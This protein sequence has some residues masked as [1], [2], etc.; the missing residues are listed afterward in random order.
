MKLK[1]AIEG[2][3]IIARYTK[4]EYC[5]GAEHDIFLCGNADLPLTDE[6]RARMKELGW[7]TSYGSWSF[8]T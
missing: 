1:D 3:Q 8:Y 6:E 5:M 2:M 4:D 7:F